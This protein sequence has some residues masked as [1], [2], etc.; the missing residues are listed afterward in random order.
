MVGVVVRVDD[1]LIG[2]FGGSRLACS[3]DAVVTASPPGASTI[4]T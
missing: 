1:V 3:I 4:T 2:L